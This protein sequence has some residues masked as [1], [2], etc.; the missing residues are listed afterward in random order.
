M[1]FGIQVVDIA[2]NIY[3]VSTSIKRYKLANYVRR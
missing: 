3:I 2:K 1:K